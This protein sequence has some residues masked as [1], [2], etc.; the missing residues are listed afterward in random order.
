LEHTYYNVTTNR[1]GVLAAGV[2]VR[3][4][5]GKVDDCAGVAVEV[6]RLGVN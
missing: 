6:A 4:E 3:L 5:V 2:V 1:D